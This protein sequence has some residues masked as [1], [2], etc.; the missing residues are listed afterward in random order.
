LLMLI[1]IY[2]HTESE[3]IFRQMR[4]LV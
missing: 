3:I 1:A 4:C 2:R